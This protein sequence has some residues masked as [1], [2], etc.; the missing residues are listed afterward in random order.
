MLGRPRPFASIRNTSLTH[1]SPAMGL[2]ENQ[3]LQHL[4]LGLASPRGL[5]GRS[6][7]SRMASRSS[8]PVPSACPTPKLHPN[9]LKPKLAVEIMPYSDI[10]TPLMTPSK[11]AESPLNL[12]MINKKLE[13]LSRNRNGQLPILEHLLC[14]EGSRPLSLG[15]CECQRSSITC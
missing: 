2:S 4:Y 14:E 9:H 1:L 7:L 10:P 3:T 15:E 8:S 6:P 13:S 5:Y 12:G 11:F